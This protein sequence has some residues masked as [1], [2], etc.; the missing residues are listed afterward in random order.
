[1]RVYDFFFGEAASFL[2]QGMSNVSSE[3]SSI[4]K[5]GGTITYTEREGGTGTDEHTESDRKRETETE[6][7]K[8]RDI[9]IER[10]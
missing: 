7:G 3:G 2:S 8:R 4:C 9:E 5:D 6:V 1:L 10:F